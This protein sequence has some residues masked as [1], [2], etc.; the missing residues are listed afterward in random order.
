MIELF[1]ESSLYCHWECSTLLEVCL[2][3]FVE[4]NVLFITAWAHWNNSLLDGNG[5]WF[6]LHPCPFMATFFTS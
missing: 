1:I 3:H 5:V 4:A 6:F 2:L